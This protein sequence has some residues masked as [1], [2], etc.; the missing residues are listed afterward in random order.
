MYK[1]TE[2]DDIDNILLKHALFGF[3]G[4]ITMFDGVKFGYSGYPMAEHWSHVGK[5]GVPMKA[6]VFGGDCTKI[7][8]HVHG[9]HPG[10]RNIT[11]Y[12]SLSKG[13]AAAKLEYEGQR[14]AVCTLSGTH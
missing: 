10:G 13:M 12:S 4:C 1:P 8:H 11:R 3:P 14:A 6:Y 9:S 2:Q 7:V 5:E